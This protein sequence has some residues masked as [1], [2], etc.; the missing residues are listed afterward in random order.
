MPTLAEQFESPDKRKQVVVDL[1]ALIDSEVAKKGGLSGL[2]IK[3][4]YAVVKAIKPTFITEVIQAIF[5]DCV[6]NIEAVYQECA[7]AGAGSFLSRWNG[8]ASTVAD[9]LLKVT[10]QR[11][12]RSKNG[13]VK[14][15]YERLRPT[16][17]RNVEEAVPGLGQVLT[18]HATV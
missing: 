17:K 13:T 14:K 5:D 15:A 1:A 8:K 12:E 7:A 16:A 18:R 11:A 9:A 4:S 3:G 6:N 2:A 10:D